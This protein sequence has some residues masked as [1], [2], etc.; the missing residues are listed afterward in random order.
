MGKA[1]GC[2]ENLTNAGKGRIKGVPNK[3]TSFKASLLQVYQD[4]GGDKAL[5]EWASRRE[6]QG[7]FYKLVAKLL[8]KEVELTGK[9][10]GPVEVKAIEVTF[11]EG[12]S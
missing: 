11:V 8:P 1:K 10:G 7:E 6:N 12:K 2:R 5:C 9:N 3:F 4:M